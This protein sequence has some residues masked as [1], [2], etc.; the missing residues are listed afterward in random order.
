MDNLVIC[1]RC[2]SDA[3][4]ETEP[5]QNVKSYHC[6]GCGFTTNTLMKEGEA[7]LEEQKEILPELYKDLMF[8]DDEG[9]IWM[10]SSVNSPEQGMVFAN[11]TGADLW[12]WSAVKAVPV[13]EE[14]K[15]KYLIKSKPGE[16]YKFRM[17]M[18]TIQHFEEGDYMDALSYIGILPQEE[19]LEDQK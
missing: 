5:Y 14:E 4:M 7:F 2:G 19:S 8:T 13:L 17:D 12:K 3:C 11:G 1:K 18:D 15:E 6:M 10:P 16:Y 9:K